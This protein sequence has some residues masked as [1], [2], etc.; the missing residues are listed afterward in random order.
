MLRCGEERRGEG[1]SMWL[2]GEKYRGGKNRR[3]RGERRKKRGCNS[4]SEGMST[5]V[6]S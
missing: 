4:T 1:V 6:V 5:G 2:R 3:G